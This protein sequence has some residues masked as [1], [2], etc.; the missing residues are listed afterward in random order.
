MLP[1]IF[2]N[3]LHVFVL[4]PHASL[5]THP[6]EKKMRIYVTADGSGYV[7]NV[8]GKYVS[9]VRYPLRRPISVNIKVLQEKK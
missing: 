2:E 7:C 3:V 5:P 9:N 1:A 6:T 4:I 8:I